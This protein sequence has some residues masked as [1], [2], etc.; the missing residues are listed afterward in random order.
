MTRKYKTSIS[1]RRRKEKD[2]KMGTANIGMCNC[3][4]LSAL[5]PGLGA[6]RLAGN[7]IL[8]VSSLIIVK[9]GNPTPR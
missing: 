6:I 9:T 2:E 3:A 1:M 4:Q 8:A 7:L 5:L